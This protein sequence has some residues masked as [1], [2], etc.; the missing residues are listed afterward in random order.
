MGNPEQ[1]QER[2]QPSWRNFIVRIATSNETESISTGYKLRGLGA[3][4]IR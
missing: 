2:L 1:L 4:G 3:P